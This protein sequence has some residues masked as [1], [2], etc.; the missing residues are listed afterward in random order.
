MKGI[1][2]RRNGKKQACEPC[3]KGKLACDHGNPF[4]GRCVRRKTTER[5]IYHPAPMTKVRPPATSPTRNTVAVDGSCPS[6][7]SPS[8]LAPLNSPTERERA[9]PNP[10]NTV[11]GSSSAL[12][13]A[14]PRA[15]GESW[16]KAVYKRSATF[17][18]PTSFTAL[19][20][21]HKATA[22]DNLLDM[23]EDM[24]R[25]PG[26]WKYGQPLGAYPLHA[27]FCSY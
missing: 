8:T 15:H 22:S 10:E 14:R 17:T 1:G 27:L 21:E 16:K 7:T 3:R 5:C 2:Y 18:G 19:F 13:A 20:Q 11:A 26:A 6:L 23:E 24:R 25:H 4:C 9:G 12:K